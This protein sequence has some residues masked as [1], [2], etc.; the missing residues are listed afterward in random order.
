MNLNESSPRSV[1]AVTGCRRI[2]PP[3]IEL[4]IIVPY[5]GREEHLQLFI[6]YIHPFLQKQQVDYRI[7][8]VE[9]VIKARIIVNHKFASWIQNILK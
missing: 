7:F 5:R 6:H 3:D 4:A 1:R 9:Q 2:A 8:I